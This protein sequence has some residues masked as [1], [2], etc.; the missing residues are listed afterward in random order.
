MKKVIFVFIAFFALAFASSVY[1]QT[2]VKAV[3]AAQFYEGGQEAMYKFIN[4]TKVYP[5]N[6]KRNRIQGECIIHVVIESDG[7]VTNATV[8]K[9]ISGGCGEEALRVVNLLKFTAPGYRFDT[10][11][12]VIFK[13]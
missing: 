3:P 7:S 1:A 2:P 8:V 6:A 12:P 5:L 13:L 11:I 9:N 10:N 4:E